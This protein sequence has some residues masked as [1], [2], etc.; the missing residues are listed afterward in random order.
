MPEAAGRGEGETADGKVTWLVDR[1]GHVLR[2][3]CRGS[4]PVHRHPPIW[5]SFATIEAGGKRRVGVLGMA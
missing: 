3:T 2:A 1:S 4:T 5:V